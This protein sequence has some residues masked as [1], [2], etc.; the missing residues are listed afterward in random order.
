MTDNSIPQGS[1]IVVTGVTGQVAL[2]VALGLAH[3]HQVIGAARFSNP[4]ARERLESGGVTCVPVDLVAGEVGALPADADYVVHFGVVKSNDW[5]T[6]LDGNV[7]GVLALMEHHRSAK[8][9]LHC[10]TT[11]V[12]RPDGH[13]PLGED[14]ALGDNHGVWE[15]LRTYSISKIAAEAAVRWAA[16]RHQLPTTIARLCV[17]YGDGG[18]WPAIHLEMVL[19]DIPVPVHVNAPSQYHPLHEDD[20]LATVPALWAAATTPATVVNWGGDQMVS[21]EE[22]CTYL[23]EL[24][25]HQAAFAPTEETIESVCLDLTKMHQVVG[26]TTVDWREGMRRMVAARHPEALSDTQQRP[27]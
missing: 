22:W 10:S 9:F 27:Q 21:I 1:K 15:F 16:R 20:I 13:R 24:V 7:G 5:S 8:A 25:G 26:K 2:P 19:S 14:D 23:G 6:D 18:G 3:H 11:G 4:A 17:P 12:Y